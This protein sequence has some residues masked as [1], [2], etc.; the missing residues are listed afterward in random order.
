[1]P[2]E[3]TTFPILRDDEVQAFFGSDT[4]AIRRYQVLRAIHTTH[5]TQREV[6]RAF[7]IS[8]RTLRTIVRNFA[9]HGS[10]DSL[11]SQRRALPKRADTQRN[12]L[13]NVLQQALA[14]QPGAGGDRL[15]RRAC[16]LLD[17][18]GPT[19]SRRTAYRILSEIRADRQNDTERMIALV[20]SALPML[21]EDPPL[22]LGTSPLAQ[23][24]LWGHSDS[25]RRGTLLQHALRQALARLRPAGPIS[26]LE[27]SWWPYL[28]C[29]GEY[30][31][32]QARAELQEQLALSVST[33]TR[34]K[35][36][37]LE[38]ISALVPSLL[39]HLLALPTVQAAQHLPRSPGFVGR[40]DE[41]AY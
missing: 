33:Y 38:R 26:S 41:Q 24:L 29:S 19:L 17:A 18:D 28:I 13:E 25:L 36:H 7:A 10:L 4:A 23:H 16:Q 27:R 30:E 31:A 22:A 34:A 14:E 35:R 2:N 1:M 12:L 5:A 37:G 15:W 6:A 20:R 32:G 11:R 8:E 39:E 9:R 3:P 21:L 40:R